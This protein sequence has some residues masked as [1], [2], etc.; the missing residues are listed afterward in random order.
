MAF[1]HKEDNG[2]LFK[3]SYKEEGSNQP[4]MKGSINVGGVIMNIAAWEKLTKDGDTMLSLKVS[5]IR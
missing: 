3:N 1:E 4:D 2:S 5:A